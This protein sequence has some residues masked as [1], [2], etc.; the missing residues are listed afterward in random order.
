ML[1][2]GASLAEV[3][4]GVASGMFTPEHYEV[5]FSPLFLFS[6]LLYLFF[7]IFLFFSLTAVELSY[8]RQSRCGDKA[9][10]SEWSGLTSC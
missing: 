3:V 1:P 2:I 8:Y 7:F 10:E 6:F 5:S 9:V 4:E